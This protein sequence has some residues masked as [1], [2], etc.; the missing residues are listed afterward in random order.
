MHAAKWHT[1]RSLAVA[2]IFSLAGAL[3]ASAADTVEW[4]Y[5]GTIGPEFWGGLSPS[6]ATCD[7]GVEQSPINIR[8]AVKDRRL[9]PIVFNYHATP[10]KVINNTHTVEVEY[11]AGS[12]MTVNGKT[13]NLLQFHFHIPSE[14]DVRG[15]EFA[16]EGHLVH[17]RGSGDSVE[18]A[19]I[20][21]LIKRGG[22]NPFIQR[23]WDVMPTDTSEAS[24]VVVEGEEVNAV[25]LLPRKRT[26]YAYDGSLT[27]PACSEG[28]KWHVLT[29]PI[30][31]SAG[32][33][34]QF[35]AIFLEPGNFPEGNARP[36]QPLN[37]RVIK[38]SKRQ[39]GD[40]D[41]DDG[42]DG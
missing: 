30:K 19:V 4:G 39:R 11:E 17:A 14:H 41:D 40:D 20:G 33:I 28:V 16:M 35:G 27:T 2:S 6:F 23:I 31:I 24:E 18:L 25:E 1:V 3:P 36:V 32:Q 8:G 37:E 42:T 22:F 9:S 10:L 15:K 12:T 26:Y 38:R 29:R 21:V 5:H 13:Y 7:A 34:D